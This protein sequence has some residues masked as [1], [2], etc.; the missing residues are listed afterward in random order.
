MAIGKF[1]IINGK[2]GSALA[3]ESLE[4]V[5]PDHRG[6]FCPLCSFLV[7]DYVVLGKKYGP[8]RHS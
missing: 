2:I 6:R 5:A 7:P 3:R 1:R 8:T 4:S